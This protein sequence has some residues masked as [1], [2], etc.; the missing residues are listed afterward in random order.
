MVRKQLNRLGR[1]PDCRRRTPAFTLIELL[2]VVAIIALLISI[3]LPSLKRARA[4]AKMVASTANARGLATAGNTFANE[5]KNALSLPRHHLMGAGLGAVGEY[6]FGGKSGAGQPQLGNDPASSLWGTQEGRGPAT[7]GLNKVLYK[8]GFPDYRNDPGPNNENWL[9]D[10][11]IDLA[12]FKAPSDTGYAGH[13]SLAWQESGLSSYDHYG[14][15][16]AAV[17]MWTGVAGGDCELSSNAAFLKPLSRIPNAANTLYIIENAGRYAA[18]KNYGASDGGACSYLSGL[19]TGDTVETVIK[20]WHG[21]PWEFAA[22]YVDGH[23][24]MVHMAGHIQPQ[25]HL[26][27]YPNGRTWENY[28][29]V[30]MRGP[31]WQIDTLPATPVP[32][33]IGCNEAGVIVNSI[34]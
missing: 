7:R 26:S 1:L 24:A 21:K 15:S 20:G 9:N 8:G 5:G 27:H 28:R 34:G 25:P 18:R 32:T 17:T 22:S 4:Q 6:E 12:I 16:Y 13:H 33:G 30:I 11:K 2:V 23:A 31:N 14:T 3:L 29:C 10:T 19:P